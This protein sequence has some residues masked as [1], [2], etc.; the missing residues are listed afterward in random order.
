MIKFLQSSNSTWRYQALPFHY[1][2][3][4]AINSYILD[5]SQVLIIEIDHNVHIFMSV[6]VYILYIHRLISSIFRTQPRNYFSE[7]TTCT[8][9][10][11]LFEISL[12]P[13]SVIRHNYYRDY[14]REILNQLENIHEIARHLLQIYI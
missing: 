10:T 6:N 14:D 2:Y 5:N 9:C 11:K 4:S 12:A 7:H 8:I 13:T 3:S 1:V